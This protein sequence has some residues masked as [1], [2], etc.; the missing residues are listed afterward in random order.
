MKLTSEI[1]KAK[2]KELGIDCIAIGNIERF[3]NAPAL[4]SPISYFPN[5]KSVIAIAMPIPRGANRGIE[6]GT[7]WHAYTFYTYNK[8]NAFFTAVTYVFRQKG[9]GLQLC[10]GQDHMETLS[11]SEFLG[12]YQAVIGYGTKSAGN[13]GVVKIGIDVGSGT[14]LGNGNAAGIQLAGIGE[15]RRGFPT[16]FFDKVGQVVSGKS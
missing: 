1:L 16:A 14:V 13:C 5:A 15:D 9:S 2:A 8:L 11:G 7:H 3:R 4:M 12:K 6:E 10:I